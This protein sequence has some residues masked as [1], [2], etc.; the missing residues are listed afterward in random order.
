[1]KILFLFISYP[2]NPNDSNL[3]KD[4]SDKFNINGEEVYIATIREKKFGKPTEYSK[5]NGVNVLRI[6]SGNMFNN[7]SKFE[8]LFTMMTMNNNILKQIKKYWGDV[9]FDIVVGTTPYMAN[10]KLINGL[11]TYYKCSSFL[12]LWD[13]FPQNAKDLELLKNKLVFNFF[14]NKE[15]KNLKSFDYIGCMSKG[16]INYVKKNYSFLDE[17]QLFLFPLWGNKKEHC[18]INKESIRKKYNFKND[19]FILVFGGNMGKPQNLG[20]VLKLAFE[21]RNIQQIKFLF[22]GRGTETEKLKKL[23]EE[24]KLENVS[25]KDFVPR[26]DYENLIS[27][28]NLGIVSLDPRFTVPNFPSKTIDY[29]KLGLPILACV[30]KCAFDDYG[31]L[32]E[33]EIKAGICC[34]ATDMQQYKENLIKLYSDKQLYLELSKNAKEYYDKFFNVENNYL[35]IKKIMGDKNDERNI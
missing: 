33:N 3:T 8:K 12:I 20:N 5:E 22:V 21:V 19:D 10:Y 15:H 24:M 27:S 18:D 17:K 28:C 9:K 6:K 13:L 23:K 30:D 31:K 4:L 29:L 7:I 32:L 26:N 2:E 16:N 11:K 34:L 14:K 35:L 25:F 1:M